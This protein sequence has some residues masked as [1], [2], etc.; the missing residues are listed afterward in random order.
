[1]ARTW[2]VSLA[3]LATV[4]PYADTLSS[5]TVIPGMVSYDQ[6]AST[7]LTKYQIPGG[8]LAVAR[9]GK[10][11]FAR[12]YGY[13]NKATGEL[14]QPDSRFRIA[15]LSKPISSAAVLLLVQ[16]GQLSLDQR[17]FDILSYEPL[18]GE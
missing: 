4:T 1:M 8:A 3:F 10:L 15:S 18:P 17:G 11:V 7:L 13:A 9:N 16:R 2:F 6:L 14:V 5:G 12:G